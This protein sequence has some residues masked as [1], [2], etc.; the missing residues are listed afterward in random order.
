MNQKYSTIFREKKVQQIV[1]ISKKK[2]E[3]KTVTTFEL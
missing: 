1:R 3:E 2:Q